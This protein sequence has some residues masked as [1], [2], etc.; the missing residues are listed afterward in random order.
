MRGQFFE[1]IKSGKRV[2]VG[3]KFIPTHRDTPEHLP[4]S[5]AWQERLRGVINDLA[6]YEAGQPT[7]AGEQQIMVSP[8]LGSTVSLGKWVGR[9]DSGEREV[10]F[11]AQL[12]D[13]AT[14]F[15]EL[16]NAYVSHDQQIF[17]CPLPE[18]EVVQNLMKAAKNT[19]NKFKGSKIARNP[20][21]GKTEEKFWQ[22]GKQCIV[23]LDEAGRGAWAGPIVAAAVLVDPSTHLP[24]V[25]DSKALSPEER[26]IM[27]QEIK[28]NA[29]FGVGSVSPEEIDN[30]GIDPANRLA[31]ERAITDLVARH[32]ETQ[33]DHVVIDGNPIKPDN[34]HIS[35]PFSC[36]TKGEVT[37]R[38][39]AA[40]SILAKTC[41]DRNMEA[42]GAEHPEYGFAEHKG[43]G[44]PQHQLALGKLGPC[45]IHR[46]SY[47]PVRA[48]MVPSL[49]I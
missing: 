38:A 23:G 24:A 12:N 33:V 37:S 26:Q 36:I 42:F 27:E 5:D 39:I 34:L 43:Y 6:G 28:Q 9:T 18:G 2:R 41:R 44:T 3:G 15:I 21:T 10:I 8:T 20:A 16:P 30:I 25:Q 14:L 7:P 31:F 13:R 17:S 45:P 22:E 32:P 49:G 11:A 4:M 48:S 47:A 1:K 29:K 46:T 19:H 40:A 35:Y